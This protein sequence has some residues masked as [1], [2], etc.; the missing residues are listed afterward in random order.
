M[1]KNLADDTHTTNLG[2][3]AGGAVATEYGDG[4]NHV[5]LLTFT[6]A[7]LT[8]GDDASLGVGV[9]IY[10]FPAGALIVN[11]AQGS[12][13]TTVDFATKTDTPEIGLGS[14]I[15]EGAIA[16]LGAGT[17][18]ENIAGP[19]VCDDMN[20]TV[21]VFDS[22]VAGSLVRPAAAAHTVH[23]NYADAW[24]DSTSDTGAVFTGTVWL[25]W[26]LFA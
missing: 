23:L 8:V 21:E 25:N 1:N 16:T 3:A 10:T 6:A 2:I 12:I 5:T 7:A 19:A 15:G 13:A 14:L 24:V 9:L 18:M 20:G 22:G 26:T 4:K 17:D 11:S